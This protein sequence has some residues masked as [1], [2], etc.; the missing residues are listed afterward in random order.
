MDAKFL[1]GIIPVGS[2]PNLLVACLVYKLAISQ[3]RPTNTGPRC[4]MKSTELD[5]PDLHASGALAQQ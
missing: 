3:F 1:N 2:A 5:H 4:K